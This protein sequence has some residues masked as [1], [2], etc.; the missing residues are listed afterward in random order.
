MNLTLR[1]WRNARSDPASQPDCKSCCD[2]VRNMGGAARG[3]T[4]GLLGT[5]AHPA[6]RYAAMLELQVQALPLSIPDFMTKETEKTDYVQVGLTWKKDKVQL[7][8]KDRENQT[9]IAE[10]DQESALTLAGQIQ[11]HALLIRTP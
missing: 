7:V 10:L 1:A 6:S 3:K 5:K 11:G 8:V 2:D 4:H 9:A